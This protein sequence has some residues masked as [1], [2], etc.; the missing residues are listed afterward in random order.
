MAAWGCLIS[1]KVNKYSLCGS[2]LI[3][4]FYACLIKANP[5]SMVNLMKK[6]E[7]VDDSSSSLQTNTTASKVDPKNERY[8]N[9]QYFK[10]LRCC[11]V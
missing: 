1:V 3:K 11:P 9:K 2:L 7:T 6:L 10:S 5:S 4:P 8:C